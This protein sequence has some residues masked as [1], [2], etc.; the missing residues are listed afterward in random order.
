MRRVLLLSLFGLL[1][2]S[3]G[4]SGPVVSPCIIEGNATGKMV[5]VDGYT[6]QSY[7]KTIDEAQNYVCLSP[8]DFEKILRSLRLPA[9][10][11]NYVWNRYLYLYAQTQQG[12]L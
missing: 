5:C 3:C 11:Q 4:G 10:I 2:L 12:M 7:F 8:S 9:S 1:S 6:D